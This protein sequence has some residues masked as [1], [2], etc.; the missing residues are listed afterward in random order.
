LEIIF[1]SSVFGGKV[2]EFGGASTPKFGA[3][4]VKNG[5]TSFSY[6]SIV[7]PQDEIVM[8]QVLIF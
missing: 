3:P 6:G 8:N 1:G 2:P 5:R 4:P 7:E